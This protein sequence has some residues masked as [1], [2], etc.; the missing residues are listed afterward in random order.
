[1]VATG[2][3]VCVSGSGAVAMSLALSLSA[4]GW[5]VAW[6]KAPEPV[7]P[8][9]PDVRTYALNA[10]AIDLLE[11]LRV[12]P[13]LKAF[14]TPVSRMAIQGDAAGALSFSAWQQKVTELAWIVDAA[15][16]ERLL[17]EALR[18]AP[19]VQVVPPVGDQ[20]ATV[21]ASLLAICEGK[22]SQT[23]ASLGI[24]F[25]RQDYGHWGVA[26]RLQATLP[27]QGVA[28]QWFRSPDILALLPFN[29]PDPDASY[30]LVWSLPRARAEA[31]MALPPEAFE[32]ALKQALTESD[33]QAAALVGDLTLASP[34]AAWPLALAQAQRWSGPGWVLLGDAAHQVHPLAGQGLNLGLA[35]VDTLVQVLD[36]ARAREPWRTPGDARTLARYARQRQWPT[37]AMATLTDGLLH[38]FAD[39]RA[40]LKTVRNLGMNMVQHLGPIKHWLAS[41]ALD[42]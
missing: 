7:S 28:R 34:V 11:R 32:Q 17:G 13:A 16:L 8:G 4:Q 18:F 9:A 26:A 36:E 2:F 20:P 29:Q 39:E 25:T 6:A 24:G 35:D 21:A 33:P 37:Q 41:R 31:L 3:D 10:R 23:R 27:H 22:H 30:G 40:P 12:W 38:L 14:A 1:M 15:A 19:R 42:S 5:Q